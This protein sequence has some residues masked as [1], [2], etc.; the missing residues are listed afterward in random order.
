MIEQD[1][2]QTLIL[3][4]KYV[5]AEPSYVTVEEEDQMIREH[6]ENLAQT[7]GLDNPIG[8]HLAIEDL[9]TDPSSASRIGD[10]LL[11]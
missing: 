1:L 8:L 11:A 2:L 3:D 10:V 7:Y 9:K 6:G 5:V 4:Q